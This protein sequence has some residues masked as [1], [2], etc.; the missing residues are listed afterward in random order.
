[1]SVDRNG[2]AALGA[3]SLVGP[4]PQPGSDQVAVKIANRVA[5]TRVWSDQ[6]SKR[7]VFGL[8]FNAGWADVVLLEK[9]S[10]F[11]TMMTGNSMKMT[12]A[13]C[14]ARWVDVAYYAT[15]IAAYVGGT[16]LFRAASKLKSTEGEGAARSCAP[17]VLVLFALSDALT[18][19]AP[20]RWP[21]V[22]LAMAFGV[23]NAAS[24][25]GART[26]TNMLTMHMHR[27]SNYVVD[28]AVGTAPAFV[29][30]DR[31]SVGVLG[32]FVIG[33]AWGITVAKL[34]PGFLA[35]GCATALGIAYAALLFSQ[36]DKGRLRLR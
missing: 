1:M 15:V 12:S 21:M 36:D 14:S 32:G 22:A 9:Y 17:A 11:P 31:R 24:F 6:P 34:F 8:A 29:E 7:L 26:I 23:I 20:A 5:T 19:S 28:R 2:T 10:C 4:R 25:E 30:A 16:M 33:A 3:A 35:H 18:W 27:L 13:L